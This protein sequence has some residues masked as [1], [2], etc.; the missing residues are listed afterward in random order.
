MAGGGFGHSLLARKL[1][2]FFPPSPDEL[3]CLAG[4]AVPARSV[5]RGKQ[6]IHEGQTKQRCLF[7]N[8][9]GRAVTKISSGGR[10]II[11]F[12]LA[13]DCVG[14]RSALLR[15]ADHSFQALAEAVVA[16]WMARG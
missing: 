16:P 12:P 6:L 9:A 13:G 14:L 2:T 10:Q 4:I 15:T 1:N 5:K 3:K 11:S 7:C 8:P